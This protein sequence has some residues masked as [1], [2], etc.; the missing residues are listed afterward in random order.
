MTFNRKTRGAR[1]SAVMA[2]ALMG[3]LGSAAHAAAS[4]L[5][6]RDYNLDGIADAYYDSST[7]LLWLADANLIHTSGYTD[8]RSSRILTLVD[9]RMNWSPATEWATALNLYG[10][11]G[12][13]LPYVGDTLSCSELYGGRNLCT[14]PV[15]RSSSELGR[16]LH[17]TLGND[18][19]ITNTGPF[20]NVQTNNFYWTSGHVSSTP[21]GSA[22]WTYY[23]GTDRYDSGH[24]SA[25]TPVAPGESSV[26]FGFAWAVHTGDVPA[27]VP[28]P[29]SATL[30]LMALGCTA[31]ASSRRKTSQSGRGR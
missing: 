2:A 29:A 11:T 10:V 28:E 4:T 26:S 15:D 6:A 21:G 18:A 27:P 7:D 17:N 16:L 25:G 19:A 3:A 22:I 5:S 1:L 20:R 8:P 30:G 31:W 9:G 13:R 14:S 12:W 24:Q 23:V